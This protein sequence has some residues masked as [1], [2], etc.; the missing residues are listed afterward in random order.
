MPQPPHLR[1]TVTAP[2]SAS[3]SAP[4]TR[5]DNL[6]SVKASEALLGENSRDSTLKLLERFA[7]AEIPGFG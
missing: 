7:Q 6:L 2:S 5:R 1:P 3:S 4:A